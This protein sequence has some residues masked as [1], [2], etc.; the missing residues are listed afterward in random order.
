MFEVQFNADEKRSV[1]DSTYKFF[2][3]VGSFF[4]LF[5]YVVD[6]GLDC[7]C[8]TY[9]QEYAITLCETYTHTYLSMHT[10][11]ASRLYTNACAEE[12]YHEFATLNVYREKK[13]IAPTETNVCEHGN[14]E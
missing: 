12:T 4:L 6:A 1:Y 9:E 13:N 10:H 5:I 3:V 8:N 2:I 14:R 7:T 11:I